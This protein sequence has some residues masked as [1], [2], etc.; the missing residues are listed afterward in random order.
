MIIDKVTNG[1]NA[2]NVN[3]NLGGKLVRKTLIIHVIHNS[4]RHVS[5]CQHLITVRLQNAEGVPL[6]IAKDTLWN[7]KSLSR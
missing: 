3:V 6:R 7:R 1:V 2:S 5:V 4:M